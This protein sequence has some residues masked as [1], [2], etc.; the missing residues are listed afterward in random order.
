MSVI[1]DF[2]RP[3]DVKRPPDVAWEAEAQRPGGWWTR[4]HGAGVTSGSVILFF[5]IWL[6]LT[7]SGLVKA[8]FLVSPLSVATEFV[9]LLKNGYTGVP[10]IDHV[11]ASVLRAVAGLS[12]ALLIGVPVG[13][14]VGWNRFTSAA[15]GPLL[16]MARPVP[17]IALIPLTVLWFGIGPGAK[18]FLVFLA[19]FLYVSLTTA[20]SVRDV[21][22]VL[23][24]AGRMLGASDR[25]IFLYVVFPESL[26]HIMNAAKVGAA[27]SWAV[28]VA[29]E[30]VGG[31]KGLGYM[32]MDAATFFRID[33]VYVGVI[34]IGIIGFAFER[35]FVS[36]ERRFVRWAGR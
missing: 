27:I 18:V 1:G 2:E 11:A 34:L 8:R 9:Y 29:A 12:I 33:D 19:G 3:T 28:V 35:I 25:Q 30:L 7:E 15:L 6:A 21:K 13:L 14:L 5:L 16:A 17:P 24:R 36:I 4:V 22:A 10:L 26:P 20:N 23:P 31:Q 32:V